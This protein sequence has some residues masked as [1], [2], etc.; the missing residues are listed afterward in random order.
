MPTIR[1]AEVNVATN[2]EEHRLD[3][4][5]LDER[6]ERAALRE[7]KAK[8]KMKGYYD[9]KERITTFRPG[10]FVYRVND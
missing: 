9:A 1:T 8:S 10:D 7:E 6:R 2:D 4:D 5:L 3:L